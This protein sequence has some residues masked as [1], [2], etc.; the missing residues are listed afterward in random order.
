MGELGAPRSVVSF[1]ALLSSCNHSKLFNRVCQL[2][3][4]MPQ[5]HGFLPDKVSYGLLVKAYCDD[6]KPELGVEKLKEMKEK[7]IEVTVITFTAIL[8]ALYK[9]GSVDEA[10]RNGMMDEA[11]KVYEGLEGNGC[12]PNGA[13]FGTMIHYGW[14]ELSLIHVFVN[15]AMSKASKCMKLY[16]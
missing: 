8:H 11:K 15:V 4:E 14:T 16:G 7:G 1:N 10:E 5:R 13:T 6:G 12:K 3:D 9:K 2:F